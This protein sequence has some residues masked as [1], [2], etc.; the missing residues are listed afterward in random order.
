MDYI[1][2]F[3]NQNSLYVWREFVVKRCLVYILR[4]IILKIQL[5]H[6]PRLFHV[7]DCMAAVF[8]LVWCSW[9]LRIAFEDSLI[10]HISEFRASLVYIVY[11]ARAV[12][13]D[14]ASEQQQIPWFAGLRYHQDQNFPPHFS[15]LSFQYCL[16]S[17]LWFRAGVSFLVVTVLKQ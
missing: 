15:C 11:L 7:Y 12:Q 8:S 17:W 4:Q 3:F 9:C 1:Q 14:P 6:T 13:R 10:R 16:C 5:H 2:F